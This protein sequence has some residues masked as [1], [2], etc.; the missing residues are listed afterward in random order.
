MTRFIEVKD[1]PLTLS[2]RPEMDTNYTYEAVY[3]HTAEAWV[4]SPIPLRTY[5]E[6]CMEAI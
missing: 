1:S 2:L 3:S 4:V 6:A 5:D